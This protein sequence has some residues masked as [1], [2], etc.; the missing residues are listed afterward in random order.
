MN[1]VS[2]DSYDAV[3]GSFCYFG[4]DGDG[5]YYSYYA[6]Q[7]FGIIGRIYMWQN[8]ANLYKPGSTTGLENLLFGLNGQFGSCSGAIPCSFCSLS[9]ISPAKKVC[10]TSG[11]ES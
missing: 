10:T 3:V 7:F 2:T 11:K 1:F 5:N 8:N 6:N 9:V 4:Y